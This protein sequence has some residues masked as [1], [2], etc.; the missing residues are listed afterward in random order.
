MYKINKTASS[1][2]IT[3]Q[4]EPARCFNTTRL[5]TAFISLRYRADSSCQ[6]E[7]K[8]PGYQCKANAGPYIFKITKSGPILRSLNKTQT[9]KALDTGAGTFPARIREIRSACEWKKIRCHGR[10]RGRT[11]RREE[12][13]LW[14][15]ER[16]RTI[17]SKLR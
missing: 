2:T 17:R 16:E 8:L 11:N 4:G 15:S 5:R 6:H 13:Q 3:K 9:A 1:L 10:I 14:K 7:L 12:N